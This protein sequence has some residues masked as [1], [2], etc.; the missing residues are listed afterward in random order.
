ME[1]IAS[2]RQ[3]ADDGSENYV[4]ALEKAVALLEEG[5]TDTKSDGLGLAQG[6]SD[7]LT[8]EGGGWTVFRK[9]LGWIIPDIRS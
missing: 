2:V 8:N 7:K 1:I 6:W 4:V 5:G 3:V 9:L